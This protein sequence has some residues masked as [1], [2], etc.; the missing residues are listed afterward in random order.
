MTS[1]E[2][3]E[4]QEAVSGPPRG[5]PGE[6]PARP[7][8]SPWGSRDLGIFVAFFL[9]AAIVFPVLA[10][11]VYA[12]LRPFMG[13]RLRAEDLTTNPFFLVSIQ[14]VSYVLV[15]GY[16][17][18]LVVFS[19][20]LSFWAG[21]KWRRPTTREA[22]AYVL[23]GVLLGVLIA[24]APPLLP[25]REDFPLERLFSSPG[26]A[27]G[28][29]VFAVAVAPF[30]EELI[31][32]GVL[33]SFFERLVGLRFAIAGTALLFAALHVPEYWRA[34]N[35]AFLILVVSVVLSLA[36]G[37]TGSLTP[38]VILHLTFNAS[39]ILAQALAPQHA[40]SVH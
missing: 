22:I 21:L 28:L 26:A 25:D 35:H 5:A 17:Y 38:S 7:A 32:R 30:V 40:G 27:Y 1:D 13:W 11:A 9:F 12:A 37:I 33:F 24:H 15:V 31:F 4:K 2:Y 36:R 39:M 18:S 14:S 23:G 34:W 10:V 6:R 8:P 20:R 3:H 29:A 19:Y 16:I